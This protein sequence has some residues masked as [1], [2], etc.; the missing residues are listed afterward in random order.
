M[1]TVN[2]YTEDGQVHCTLSLTVE[3][4]AP[5]AVSM[6][7]VLQRCSVC[8]HIQCRY[9]F[10][11]VQLCIYIKLCIIMVVCVMYLYVL[12]VCVCVYE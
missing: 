3:T 8:M 11:C 12:H 5:V 10:T 9:G 2:V 7:Y 1:Y 4:C 6:G